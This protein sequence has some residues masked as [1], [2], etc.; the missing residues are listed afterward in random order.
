MNQFAQ[1]ADP[2]DLDRIREVIA[3]SPRPEALDRLDLSAL[4]W[5]S[6]ISRAYVPDSGAL[7][8][9][10]TVGHWNACLNP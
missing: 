9:L 2:T 8:T 10:P 7:E 5:V 6:R 1:I 3:A 4:C